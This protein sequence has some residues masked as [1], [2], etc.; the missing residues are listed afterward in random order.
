MA[1]GGKRKAQAKRRG[2]QL[3]TAD[4]KTGLYTKLTLLANMLRNYAASL[5]L[6]K[7]RA[8]ACFECGIA[9]PRGA[10]FM[11][12]HVFCEDHIDD[13]KAR[14]IACWR[15][16]MGR[17]RRQTGKLLSGNCGREGGLKVGA[18]LFCTSRKI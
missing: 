4:T 8:S 18:P 15:I 1:I 2:H 5:E 12:G 6:A 13:V 9:C 11:C 10:C 17:C 14:A 16:Y 7:E 3:K